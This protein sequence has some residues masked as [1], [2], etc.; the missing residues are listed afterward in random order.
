MKPIV[1]MTK[2]QSGGVFRKRDLLVLCLMI[3]GLYLT[4][5]SASFTF[6][7][8]P[9]W[10]IDQRFKTEST[11]YD[12]I[13][14]IIC[15][16]NGDG[17]KEI[18]L[19]SKDADDLSL[20]I[21]SANTPKGS[22][23]SIYSPKVIASI[24]LMP[25]KVT[26]GRIPVALKTGYIDAYDPEKGRTQVI[27]VLR[28]DWTVIC[29]DSQLNVRWEKAIAHKTHE[30]DDMIDK[31]TIDE[32]AIYLTP[33]SLTDDINGLVIV[34]GS[35]KLRDPSE[36]T[37]HVEEGLDMKEN[38]DKEHPEMKQR[39][40]LE[41]FSMYALDAK[42]GHVVWRHDGLDVHPGQY[43]RGLP[44]HAYNLDIHDLMSKAHQA[45][46]VTDW[47]VFRESLI[48]ELPHDWHTRDDTSIRMAHFERQH[49]GGNIHRK[50]EQHKINTA[51]VNTGKKLLASTIHDP[52]KGSSIM[53]L[54]N[55]IL[56]LT[57]TIQTTELIRTPS[58]L[59][60]AN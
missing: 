30:M 9:A 39:A 15:D 31:F 23:G 12:I 51:S 29:Y 28:E 41:H 40:A 47:S 35:M 57:T 54:L 55:T 25:L 37:I 58:S 33:L 1:S 44:Q 38:G 4:Y 6:T 53:S 19:I 36:E 56:F 13:P 20:K 5:D 50:R 59:T 22:T 16:L 14:P 49:I 52:R 27:V 2:E 7:L 46:T 42:T 60:H 11:S 24:P 48:G 10:Y 18:V 21:V 3:L 34:G 8:E 45:P 26:K 32:V 43:I 17:E